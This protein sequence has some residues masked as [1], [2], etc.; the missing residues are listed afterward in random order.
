MHFL[1]IDHIVITT[2]DLQRCLDFYVGLLGLEHI[3]VNGRH[4]LA[5]GQQKINIH[6]RPGEFLPSAVRATPG[7]Q[8]ICLVADCPAEEILLAI[9]AKGYPVLEGIVQR[10]GALGKINSVYL[11][12]PDGNLVEI[13]SYLE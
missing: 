2:S 7:S 11:H 1:R 9:E 8:D 6:T 13:A 10:Q 12:D 4:S 3:Q 5:L